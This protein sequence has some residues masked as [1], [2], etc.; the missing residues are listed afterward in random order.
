MLTMQDERMLKR[1]GISAQ[2]LRPP[3]PQPGDAHYECLTRYLQERDG[4]ERAERALYAEADSFR[5]NLEVSEGK[6]SAWR[7][8]AYYWSFIAAM[9]AVACLC[10]VAR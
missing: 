8:L 3:P 6:A 10:L 5:A 7:K 1:M 9:L 2:P 4:R